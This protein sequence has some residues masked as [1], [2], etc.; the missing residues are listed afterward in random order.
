[1]KD[2]ESLF[3]KA[4]ILRERGRGREGEGMRNVLIPRGSEQTAN[5]EEEGGQRKDRVEKLETQGARRQGLT[6]SRLSSPLGLPWFRI[7]K[8]PADRRGHVG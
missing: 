3:N 8:P 1:M 6:T 4:A 2:R 5:E 7:P